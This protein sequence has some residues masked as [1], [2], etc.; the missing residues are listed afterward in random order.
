MI[1]AALNFKLGRVDIAR[2]YSNNGTR[3]NSSFANLEVSEDSVSIMEAGKSTI[4]GKGTRM[5]VFI[6]VY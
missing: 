3:E 2:I 1:F 4:P 6:S 5:S